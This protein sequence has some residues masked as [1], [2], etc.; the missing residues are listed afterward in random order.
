MKSSRYILLSFSLCLSLLSCQ[1]PADSQEE[2]PAGSNFNRAI[3]LVLGQPHFDQIEESGNADHFSVFIGEDRL[4]IAMINPAPAGI[5]LVLELYDVAQER[6][7]FVVGAVGQPVT[8]EYLAAAGTYYLRV[9]DRNNNAESQDP[10]TLTVV[11]DSSDIYELNNTFADAVPLDWS[12]SID[13]AVRPLGDIDNFELI[14]PR[15]GV[16][17]IAIDPVPSGV[18]VIAELFD[19]N[20]NRLTWSTA[21][22]GQSV[23]FNYLVASGNYY[24]R[25]SDRNNNAASDVLYRVIADFDSTDRYEL[26]NSF[27]EASEVSIGDSLIATSRSVGDIDYYRFVTGKPGVIDVHLAKVPD[28]VDLVAEL[29]NDQQVRLQQT[30]GGFGQP[31][32]LEYL[33]DAGSYYLRIFDRNLN[34]SS[35][36]PYRAFLSLDASDPY[37]I[38]N[39][40]NQA[41]AIVTGMA[42]QA[43]IRAIGDHDYYRLDQALSGNIT[44]SVTPVPAAIDV[45]ALIYNASQVEIARFIGG[46]GQPVDLTVDVT[47]ISGPIYV[48]LYDRNN[49]AA[50]AEFYTLMVQ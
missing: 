29:Y 4:L 13:G 5:D 41:A 11:A 17:D 21:S 16:V 15:A 47:G 22:P 10:Y 9:T 42:Y 39:T 40:F 26:N 25:L 38:N 33:G 1:Q 30:I 6:I 32:R 24:L 19:G 37:E 34:N 7:G 36:Q 43:K 8:L 12:V 45:V 35:A 28:G 46:I 49:N 50:S 48:R 3:P 31:I 23:F 27:G 14:A 20:Q 18:D 2:D 44:I